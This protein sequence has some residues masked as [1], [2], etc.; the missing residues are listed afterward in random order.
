MSFKERIRYVQG[1]LSQEEFGALLWGA[2][3]YKVRA[4]EAGEGMPRSEILALFLESFN[5]N[6]NWLFLGKW[7]PSLDSQG[8]RGDQVDN[9]D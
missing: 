6:L 3:R 9:P 4:W 1:G 5:V 7:G 2:Y 8:H